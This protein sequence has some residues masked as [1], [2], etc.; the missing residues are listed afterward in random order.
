MV[1]FHPS[2]H[3]TA[4][5]GSAYYIELDILCTVL[6]SCTPDRIKLSGKYNGTDSVLCHLKAQPR[7]RGANVTFCHG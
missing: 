1:M 6:L 2:M 5:A 7:R 4:L 3:E